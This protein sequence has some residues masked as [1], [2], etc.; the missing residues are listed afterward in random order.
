[1]CRFF[2]VMVKRFFFSVVMVMVLDTRIKAYLIKQ[3]TIVTKK[4]YSKLFTLRTQ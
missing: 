1:M 3:I 4:E 2:V